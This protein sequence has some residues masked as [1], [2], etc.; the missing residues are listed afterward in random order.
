MT[1]FQSSGDILRKTPSRV[2]PALL[3]RTST[4][5]TSALTLLNAAT[6]LSQSPTLPSEAMKS[7]PRAFWSASHLSQGRV[8]TATGHHGESILGQPLADRSADT[9]HAARYVG[10][11]S[12]SFSSSCLISRTEFQPH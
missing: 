4:S 6:V 8:G 7:K 9:A 12:C 2:M 3:T 10:N 5:P 11:F 1:A